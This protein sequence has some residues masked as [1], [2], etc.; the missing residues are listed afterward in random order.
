MRSLVNGRC[1]VSV[2]CGDGTSWVLFV[3]VIPYRF[4]CD[5]GHKYML[6]FFSLSTMSS[7]RGP[8]PTIS[9]GL[10]RVSEKS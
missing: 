9:M 2:L 7:V 4:D 6:L 5:V 10:P 1:L 8:A 3:F